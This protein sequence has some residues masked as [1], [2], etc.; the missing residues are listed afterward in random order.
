M[1]TS[2]IRRFLI[3]PPILLGLAILFYVARNKTAPVQAEPQEQSQTVRTITAK[4]VPVV[5][6]I[7]GYGVVE[8]A[9]TWNAV[10]QVAGRIDY[11]HPGFKKGNILSAGTEI[12]RISPE[13]YDIAIRQAEANIRAAD[14]KLQELEQSVSNTRKS[15]DIE[16]QSLAINEKELARKTKLRKSGT[17]AASTL[18]QERKSL[19][20]QRNRV[21]ELE[22]ALR[23]TPTQIEAQRQQKAVYQTQLETAQLNRQRTSIKLPFT[24]RISASDIEVTQF[25]AVGSQLGAADSVDAAEITAQISPQHL[26]GLMQAITAGTPS[27]TV[28]IGE[29]VLTEVAKQL[30]LHAIVRLTG[31][32]KVIEWPGRLVRI[33]DTIDTKTRTVGVIIAVDSAGKG[34]IPGKRP[35]L[36][37]GM[38][39]EVEIQARKLDDQLIVLRTALHGDKLYIADKDNR[40]RIRPITVRLTQGDFVLVETGLKEGERVIVSDLLPAIDGMLLRVK[41]DQEVMHRLTK[42]A[43]GEGSIR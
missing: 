16:R 3:F 30:G 40:L 1:Q 23:L 14:A 43:S 4:R 38:F 8:L 33:S 13:D 37:K 26:L 41:D 29:G 36:V 42:Q 25:V 6:R 20:T 24:G 27:K 11:V 12:I 19:L 28:E 5:P 34:I 15:L 32:G 9:R 35:P 21:L 17:V 7:L 2:W 18:D 10:A 22:N 31:N 39:S